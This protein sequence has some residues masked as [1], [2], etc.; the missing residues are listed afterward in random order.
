VRKKIF[1]FFSFTCRCWAPGIANHPCRIDESA[2]YLGGVALIF[3][4]FNAGLIWLDFFLGAL[5]GL[6]SWGFG[7]GFW[8]ACLLRCLC[9]FS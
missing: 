6:G 2:L 5:S 9:E 7:G 4:E 3:A 8:G 1:P